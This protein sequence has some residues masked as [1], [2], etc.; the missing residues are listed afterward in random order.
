[1]QYSWNHLHL[2]EPIPQPSIIP[3]RDL[4]ACVLDGNENA[5]AELHTRYQKVVVHIVRRYF[6]RGDEVEEMVQLIFIKVWT[7]IHH[8]RG[9]HAQSFAAWI[10]R[11]ATNSCYDELRRRQRN[12]E[13]IISQLSEDENSRL[14]DLRSVFATEHQ[15][16]ATTVVRDLLQKL[17]TGLEP[18]DRQIFVMLKA[19]NQSIAEIAAVTGWS[20]VKIKMRIRRSRFLLQRRSRKLI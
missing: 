3:D 2:P 18:R 19:E 14:Y 12:K 5:F 9:E 16:E 7:G 20:E 13:Y 15:I 6:Q 8:F 4:A 11:V 1:M 10:V 17:L